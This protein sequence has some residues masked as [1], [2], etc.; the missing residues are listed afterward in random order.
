MSYTDAFENV[1]LDD[2]K[3]LFSEDD[4]DKRKRF[5]CKLLS[6]IREPSD[7]RIITLL[8]NLC[9]QYNQF[10]NDD[11]DTAACEKAK[12]YHGCLFELFNWIV[13]FE[14]AYHKL[15]LYTNLCILSDDD[16]N[17]SFC[18]E[19]FSA[20][21][22]N[23]TE[24][25]KEYNDNAI[26]KDVNSVSEEQRKILCNALYFL[27]FLNFREH[28]Y[29]DA[30]ICFTSCVSILI[31]SYSEKGMASFTDLWVKEL[32]YN[33]T[34]RLANCCEYQDKTWDAIAYMLGL[35]DD[36]KN[37][38]TKWIEHIGSKANL[39]HNE[40]LRYYQMPKAETSC[41]TAKDKTISI[42]KAICEYLTGS[43]R[44]SN[45]VV[46]FELDGGP[47]KPLASTVKLY[48]HV[49]AH[50]LSEYA[51][52]L[53]RL[54]V[55]S[56]QESIFPACSTLQLVSRFL[57]DWLVLSCGE[58][59]LVSCQ[60]T[61]RAE[62][63]ACP[64]AIALLL[65][66]YCSLEN[67]KTNLSEGSSER[68]MCERELTEVSFYLF[69]FSEQE[70]RANYQDEKLEDIFIKYGDLFRQS[71]EYSSENGDYD[72][73][74]HYYVIRVKY[75]LKRK[76][77]SLLRVSENTDYSDLDYEFTQMCKYKENCSKHIFSGLTEE[78]DRL[79]TLYSFF[80]KFRWL[81]QDTYNPNVISELEF[82]RSCSGKKIGL[83]DCSQGNEVASAEDGQYRELVNA[84]YGNIQ[85]RKKILILAPVKDAPSCAPEFEDIKK[86]LEFVPSQQSI[87]ESDN[88]VY[89]SLLE[90]A[91]SQ[92]GEVLKL[93][94][95]NPLLDF[96]R[97]K[98]A[99]HIDTTGSHGENISIGNTYL[100]SKRD[101]FVQKEY[102]ESIPLIMEEVESNKLEKLIKSIKANLKPGQRV[103][104]QKKCL[105]EQHDSAYGSQ[106]CTYYVLHSNATDDFLKCMSELLVF[107]EYDFHASLSYP[108]SGDDVILVSN[109]KKSP[110]QFF[111]VLVFD[112]P[113]AIPAT[114]GGKGLCSLCESWCTDVEQPMHLSETQIMEEA[115]K[116]QK[117][118]FCD[119]G[120]EEINK[121]L[122]DLRLIK[123]NEGSEQTKNKEMVDSFIEKVDE[124]CA[125]GQCKKEQEY[126]YVLHAKKLWKLS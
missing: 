38:Q 100:Y 65:Q 96:S 17:S 88:P 54:E 28:H 20:C 52:K 26:F 51:A 2:V 71:A 86:L 37:D 110:H 103:E 72:A 14:N 25:V 122:K 49:L 73:L 36:C 11:H 8:N 85:E 116:K 70:L 124:S 126:C 61:I 18:Y 95:L 47:Q 7:N 46:V 82:L 55:E 98:L 66:R 121:T 43:P 120:M 34:V 29:L 74:F 35:S 106:C 23:A 58:E 113:S 76:A 41:K 6:C 112:S 44:S 101:D 93:K 10:Y 19:H 21:L 57:L 84:V 3:R 94:E 108:I 27:G 123:L 114:T 62:N 68:E 53:R 4:I 33:C 40:V 9:E 56:S 5:F 77:E 78:Y 92:D 115:T 105:R 63:D 119:L 83:I 102:R 16:S 1:T 79:V 50:C 118:I 39:I 32:Y 125:K 15:V 30:K 42:V 64:E 13:P 45:H 117:E 80:Q 81:T 22:K 24:F 97:L 48:V 109:P 90:E 111:S 69:Y 59:S 87:T 67:Q 75:L 12:E 91:D 60:A 99:I 104:N 31:K 107:L 89:R